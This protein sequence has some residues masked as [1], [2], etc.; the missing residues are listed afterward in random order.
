M[1]FIYFNLKTVF[2]HINSMRLL[3]YEKSLLYCL[4]FQ[5]GGFVLPFTVIGIIMFL[6][7]PV[8]IIYLPQREG[9]YYN[10]IVL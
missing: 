7:I 6:C 4:V 3:K 9:K 8:N 2:S 1:H 10:I 5:A